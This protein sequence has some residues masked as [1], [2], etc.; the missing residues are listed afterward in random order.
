VNG[1]HDLQKSKAGVYT[2][3]LPTLRKLKKYYKNIKILLNLNL[4]IVLF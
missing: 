1:R 4:P 2:Q 3:R